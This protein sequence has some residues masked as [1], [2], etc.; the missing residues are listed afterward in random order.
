MNKSLTLN[1]LAANVARGANIELES[2]ANLVLRASV[3]QARGLAIVGIAARKGASA[4]ELLNQIQQKYA[5][6]AEAYGKTAA[7]AQERFKVA[8]ENTQEVIGAAVLPTLT[9]ALDKATDWL[10]NSKNQERIQRDVNQGLHVLTGLIETTA[11]TYDVATEAGG[12]FAHALNN[13]DKALGGGTENLKKNQTEFEKIVA[14]YQ[15]GLK[16]IADGYVG[17]EEA[18]RGAGST[19][20]EEHL[21]TGQFSQPGLGKPETPA[22]RLQRAVDQAGLTPGTADDEAALRAQTAER[23]KALRYA[24]QQIRL[25]RGNLKNYSDA[26]QNLSREIA[27]NDQKLA[28]FA[29]DRARAAEEAKQ[30]ALDA[31]KKEQQARVDAFTANLEGINLGAATRTGGLFGDLALVTKEAGQRAAARAQSLTNIPAALALRE[32]IKAAS[33]DDQK[34]ERKLIPFI[35][36]ERDAVKKNLERLKETGKFKLEQLQAILTIAQLNK[37]IRDIRNADKNAADSF[38][39]QDLFG[40]GGKQFAAYGSN[41][42][43]LSQPLSRQEAGGSAVRAAQASKSIHITQNFIGARDAAQAIHE[44][45]NAARALR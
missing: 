14:T 25:R 21:Q 31:A 15:A 35:E 1:A 13:I 9:K 11:R 38:S 32:Q 10:N 37:R 36:A 18:R 17:I 41:V 23:E 7:G 44:A 8:L 3:G 26:V 33:I 28:G 43:P 39:L 22:Q 5:G 19:L 12:R 16:V 40:E 4:T 24:L 29:E 30:K 20:R 6:S 42:A 45:A 34:N 27:A 2:A